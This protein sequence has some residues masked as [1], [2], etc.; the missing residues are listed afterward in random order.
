MGYIY[1]I[2]NP[3]GR[4]YIGKTYNIKH[5]I[6]SHKYSAKSGKNI[7][8]QNSIRKYGWDNHILDVIEEVEDDRL[9]ERETFWIKEL[10]T[11]CYE[12][13]NGMNMTLGG[14]GQ[15]STWMH[16][17]ERRKKASK[18]F[19]EH[20]P[21]KG[22]KHSKETKDI[23]GGKA[24]VRNKENGWIVPKWGATKGILISSNPVIAY[25]SEGN[26]IAEYFSQNEAGRVLGLSGSCVNEIVRG[27]RDHSKGYVFR[28]KTDN[29]ALNIDV[30]KINFR[31]SNNP[32]AI[33]IVN[34]SNEI[35]KEFASATE[36]AKE[37]KV[38]KNQIIRAAGG[39]YKK[40]NKRNGYNFIYKDLY[41][42]QLKT[43]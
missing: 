12:N 23:I 3:K 8:L 13:G 28:D 11:Y 39:F 16:D 1:K 27:H 15:R 22:K 24:S 20:N 40:T 26:F 9:N 32:R 14:D 10:K 41:L 2:E 34:N 37:I 42:S 21:F 30:S 7:I 43:A 33:L 31:N 29:Y 25:D 35:L 6:A 19:S 18:Y 36:A 17:T 4:Q 5:R 38:P